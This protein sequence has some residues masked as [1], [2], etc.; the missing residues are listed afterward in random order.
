MPALARLSTCSYDSNRRAQTV[1]D[2]ERNQDDYGEVARS[3]HCPTSPRFTAPMPGLAFALALGVL[4]TST[5]AMSQRHTGPVSVKGY[6]RKDGTYVAPHFRSAPDGTT[7]NNW[8]TQGNVNPFKGAPATKPTSSSLPPV[9]ASS[10]SGPT[11]Q[12]SFALD[13]APRS[14]APGPSPS[15]GGPRQLDEPSKLSPRQGWQ[16]TGAA[17]SSL[18][19]ALADAGTIGFVCTEGYSRSPCR[20]TSPAFPLAAKEIPVE[21]AIFFTARNRVSDRIEVWGFPSAANCQEQSQFLA[22]YSQGDYEAPSECVVLSAK[23]LPSSARGPIQG[24]AT[25][26]S[27]SAPPARSATLS[28]DGLL[29]PPPGNHVEHAPKEGAANPDTDADIVARLLARQD[30]HLRVCRIIRQLGSKVD[31]LTTTEAA[32]LIS[33]SIPDFT[34]SDFVQ[35]AARYHVIRCLEPHTGHIDNCSL[36]TILRRHEG[37]CR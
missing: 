36:G 1:I 8:S 19:T 9:P 25:N 6:V 13:Q 7:L 30:K 37:Q 29:S 4:L 2:P 11:G 34:E 16:L 17:F 5:P 18:S 20:P 28:G 32:H 35:I 31:G 10:H 3:R 22:S 12:N 14:R 33:E 24:P 27:P 15:G 26:E 21:R 23:D